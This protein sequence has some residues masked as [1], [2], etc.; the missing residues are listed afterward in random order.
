LSKAKKSARKSTSTNKKSQKSSVQIISVKNIRSEKQPDTQREKSLS[1]SS[2][3]HP[4]FSS[5]DIETPIHNQ[6]V[7]YPDLDSSPSN[8]ESS[9]EAGSEENSSPNPFLNLVPEKP[10]VASSPILLPQERKQ[11]KE[12]GYSLDTKLLNDEFFYI[13]LDKM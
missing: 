6:E 12:F 3:D 7:P 9:N 2:D 11:A 13:D 1:D 10:M 5:D 8:K 4:S